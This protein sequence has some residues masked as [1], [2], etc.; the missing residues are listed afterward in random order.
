MT[1]WV[2]GP[3]PMGPPWA[4]Y[5]E[6]NLPKAPLRP[7]PPGPNIVLAPTMRPLRN[8]KNLY[9]RPKDKIQTTVQCQETWKSP[10]LLI[11]NLLGK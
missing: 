2:R 5:P 1:G 3:V 9:M 6:A 7:R 11:V 10:F 8:V 4:P